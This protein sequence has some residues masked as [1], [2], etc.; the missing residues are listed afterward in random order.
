[1]NLMDLIKNYFNGK[2]FSK[3]WVLPTFY[4]NPKEPT[5]PSIPEG[6]KIEVIKSPNYSNRPLNQAIRLIVLHNTSS[7][8]IESTISWFKS[9]ESKVSAHYVIGRD[10]RVVRMV[11]DMFKAWDCGISE[12][13]G[14]KNCND[15]SIGIELVASDSQQFTDKQYDS[16]NKV[17]KLIKSKYQIDAI[18]G[19]CDIALPKGRKID[20]KNLDWSKVTK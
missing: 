12:W 7:S 9:T 14:N 19:H 18:V 11:E 15:F 3:S 13:N 5:K 4:I 6:L 16:L 20:P 10:G 1:M 8:D 2:Y 17:I